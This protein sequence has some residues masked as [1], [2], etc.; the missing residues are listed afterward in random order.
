LGIAIVDIRDEGA[1]VH[2]AHAQAELTAGLGVAMAT[3]GP[4]VT[5]CVPGLADS[6]RRGTESYTEAAALG[7]L[8]RRVAIRALDITGGAVPA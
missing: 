8:A 4:G 5:N 2:L 3:A 1:A 6:A 7:P